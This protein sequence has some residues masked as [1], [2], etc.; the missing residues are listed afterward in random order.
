[1][2][3]LIKAPFQWLQNYLISPTHQWWVDNVW[4][5]SWTKFTALVMAVPSLLIE[6]GQELAKWS[7]D[8]TITGYLTQ[9][10]VPNGVFAGLGVIGL[11]F[12]VASGRD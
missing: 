11:V 5:P 4:R 9:I 12:Y 10:G 3:N 8:S 2:L 1:M 6:G 7:G